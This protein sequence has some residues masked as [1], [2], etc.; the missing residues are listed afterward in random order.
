[1]S[2]NNTPV[3]VSEVV[4]YE[5]EG[6]ALTVQAWSF[7]KLALQTYSSQALFAVGSFVRL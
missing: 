5:R 1:M 4:T 7:K 2:I 6:N 3:L